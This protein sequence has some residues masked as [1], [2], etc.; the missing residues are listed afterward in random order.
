MQLYFVNDLRVSEIDSNLTDS[1]TGNGS[2][3]LIKFY[4]DL[5]DASDA[6][7]EV[8]KDFVNKV[9]REIYCK[10]QWKCARKHLIN[11]FKELDENHPSMYERRNIIEDSQTQQRIRYNIPTC[12]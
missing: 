8:R 4:T 7:A 6:V 1:L 2:T 3:Q 10:E 12:I 5:Q 9:T 11:M